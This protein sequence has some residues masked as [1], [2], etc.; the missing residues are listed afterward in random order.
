MVNAA[1]K[2]TTVLQGGHLKE[3]NVTG[4]YSSEHT[5]R[6]ASSALDP[7]CTQTARHPTVLSPSERACGKLHGRMLFSTERS[8]HQALSPGS[9]LALAVAHGHTAHRRTSVRRIRS[10]SRPSNTFML[11]STTGHVHLSAKLATG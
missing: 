3:N 6:L 5:G 11:L 7:C 10:D 1:S 2:N 4:T 8:S 9:Y